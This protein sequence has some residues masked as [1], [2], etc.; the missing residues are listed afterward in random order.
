MKKLTFIIIA[1]CL[2][3]TVTKAQS[4]QDSIDIRV[5]VSNYIEGWYSGDS[6]RMEKSLHSELAKRGVVPSRDGKS[7]EIV[8]A[9][10]SEMVQWTKQSPNLMKEKKV[11]TSDLKIIVLEIGMNMANVKCVSPQFID[12][13]HLVRINNE[14][15]IINAIWEPNYKKPAKK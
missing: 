11:L 6:G 9:S 13:L 5:T 3:Q 12:Y 2:I 8:M 10:F 4:K 1:F 14:W 15:K 7:T